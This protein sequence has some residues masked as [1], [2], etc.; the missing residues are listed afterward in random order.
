[1]LGLSVEEV[2]DALLSGHVQAQCGLGSNSSGRLHLADI[3]TFALPVDGSQTGPLAGSKTCLCVARG[4]RPS[5]FSRI[6]AP[7][8]A[9]TKT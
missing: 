2:I 5:G 9:A 4:S 3:P 1:M 8:T 6:G 7:W